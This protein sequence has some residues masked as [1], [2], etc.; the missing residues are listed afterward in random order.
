MAKPTSKKKEQPM[1]RHMFSTQQTRPTMVRIEKTSSDARMN[2]ILHEVGQ[3]D[4][5]LR[6]GSRRSGNSKQD[7]L[8][9]GAPWL[10]PSSVADYCGGGQPWL[11]A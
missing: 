8:S 9:C 3:M 2:S 11:P 1:V 4:T 5:P 6:I 7:G 10:Y